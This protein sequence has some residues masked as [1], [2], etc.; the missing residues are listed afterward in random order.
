MVMPIMMMM[1]V[2]YLIYPLFRWRRGGDQNTFFIPFREITSDVSPTKT[3]TWNLQSYHRANITMFTIWIKLI[4]DDER[5]KIKGDHEI[6]SRLFS[7]ILKTSCSGT[8]ED[9]KKLFFFRQEY[10][11]L[12][13][14]VTDSSGGDNILMTSQLFTCVWSEYE[15]TWALE[16]RARG[17]YWQT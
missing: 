17:S 14:D 1:V 7:L 16:R 4:L 5:R 11:L 9:E 10:E 12:I 15:R 3:I 2:S 13:I 8:G 6:V